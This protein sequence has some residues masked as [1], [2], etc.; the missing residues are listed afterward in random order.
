[1]ISRNEKGKLS[2]KTLDIQIF[3]DDLFALCKTESEVEWVQ[4]ILDSA[5]EVSHD[6][7]LERI[8]DGI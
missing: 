7:Q 4:E 5:M 1:M 2:A 6:D 8:E 3:F